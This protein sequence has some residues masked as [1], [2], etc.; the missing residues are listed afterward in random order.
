MN[1]QSLIVRIIADANRYTHGM[2][3]A[4]GATRRFAIRAKSEFDRVRNM[5]GSMRGQLASLGLGV[6]AV[7]IIVDTASFE[8]DMRRL[9]VNIGASRAEMEAWRKEAFE[10]QKNYGTSVG[11]QKDLADSLQAAG[12]EMTAIRQAASPV[13]KALQVAKTSADSLGKALGVAQ[14]QFKVDLN[15]QKETADLL[16]KMVVSGRLGNAELENLPDIFARVGGRAKEANFNLDQTLALVEVLSKS[17]PQS[18]RL[19]TLVDSTL[20]VFTNAK[21]M[22]EASK[23]TGVGFF[24]TQGAR[25]N[26]IDVIA[27]IKKAYDRL[28]TDAQ[29]NQFLDKAFGKTDMDTQR[30]LKKALEEGTLGLIEQYHREIASASGTIDK[31]LKTAMDNATTQASRL[32]GALQEAVEN[33]FAR[34]I[35][36]AFSAGVK[37]MMDSSEQGGWGLSGNQ[38]LAGS[39]AG[40]MGTYALGRV[41]KGVIGKLGRNVSGT[42]AG[43]VQGKV[44]EQAG[45]QPVYVVNMSEGGMGGGMGDLPGNA[46]KAGGA[47]RAAGWLRAAKFGGTL[48]LAAAP[49][50]AMYGVSEWASQRDKYDERAAGMVDFSNT[51]EKWARQIFGIKTGRE[52]YLGARIEQLKE[53]SPKAAA[54]YQ[55]ELTQLKA[56]LDGKPVSPPVPFLQPQQPI[57]PPINSP[58]FGQ[59]NRNSTDVPEKSAQAITKAGDAVVVQA[60][61]TIKTAL[62]EV[63]R[64]KI[65]GDIRV[66]VTAPAGLGVTA[67]ASGNSNTRLTA[68]VGQTNTGAK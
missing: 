53:T 31:D 44:W 66:N 19:S 68:N 26:P 47:A 28:T 42:A 60:Q 15:N 23:A 27:D 32:K 25:R 49:L 34:P 40:M 52:K 29:R 7:K 64:T 67:Q 61:N 12:L 3:A 59:T 4:A 63:S 14:E 43:V 36:D 13:S 54:A 11:D 65:Q 9:Q 37:K 24:D 33:G 1:N 50:A 39:A 55:I 20:R 35:G 38:M 6:G 5:M 16:D 17:E 22:R 45:V 2:N 51:M 8:R 21:Y 62:S 58:Y 18:D 57:V 41:G 56:K 48:T 46:G 10:N 30:G